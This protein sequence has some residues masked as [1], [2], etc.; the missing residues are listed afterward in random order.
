MPETMTPPPETDFSLPGEAMASWQT[1]FEDKWVSIDGEPTQVGFSRL[2]SDDDTGEVSSRY[3]PLDHLAGEQLVFEAD[4][5][6][7]GNRIPMIATT[8]GELV[9]VDTW[10]GDAE[11]EN[12]GLTWESAT[13]HEAELDPRVQLGIKVSEPY[14]DTVAIADVVRIVQQIVS[15][16]SDPTQLSKSR[17]SLLAQYHPDRSAGDPR[18]QKRLEEASKLISHL[19][20]KKS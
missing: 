12:S 4:P 20:D 7:P 11:A 14:K 8:T 6:D 13:S 18:E 3:H 2:E 5:D 17:K 16:E 10:L 1:D 9:S 19:F 15:A